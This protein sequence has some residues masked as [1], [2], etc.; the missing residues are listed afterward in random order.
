MQL[1][2]KQAIAFLYCTNSP[3]SIRLYKT[4]CGY[5]SQ[6]IY[7]SAQG[8]TLFIKKVLKLEIGQGASFNRKSSIPSFTGAVPFI[9]IQNAF[10][11]ALVTLRYTIHYYG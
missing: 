3:L 5:S 7:S 2:R 9:L 11:V 6:R 8:V 10:H 1:N 4:K